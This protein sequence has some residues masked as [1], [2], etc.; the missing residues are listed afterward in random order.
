M[1]L[2]LPHHLAQTRAQGLVQGEPVAQFELGSQRNFIYLLIDW[3]A[4]EAVLM[5]CRA[6]FKTVLDALHTHSLRL[7]QV[8]LTHSHHD[9]VS[10]LEALIQQ[11]PKL[12]I[13]VHPEELQRLPA[14]WAQWPQIQHLQDGQELNVG[15]I[16]ARVLHTPGH[17]R[18]ECCYHVAATA[19]EFRQTRNST[20]DEGITSLP[21]SPNTKLE[22]GYLFTG[23]TL[24]IRDCG[25]TD[26]DGGS[27]EEMFASLQRIKQLPPETV[28]LPG[29][30]Y[31]PECASTLKKEMQESPPLKCTSVAELASLE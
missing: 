27:N 7:T 30:H 21:I 9:H 31:K 19:S 1:S 20:R 22:V 13:Y 16:K 25:R 12:K 5:D 3:Q 11:R 17:S 26:F 8:W 24:F 23:D 15:E 14:A 6:E 29:H 4:R 2:P 28:I 10:G 18:G